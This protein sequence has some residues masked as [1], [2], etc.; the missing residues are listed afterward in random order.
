MKTLDIL[1]LT[2]ISLLVE[3]KGLT[4]TKIHTWSHI[5]IIDIIQK[6]ED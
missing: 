6:L 5:N 2:G 3:Y 4:A 1:N